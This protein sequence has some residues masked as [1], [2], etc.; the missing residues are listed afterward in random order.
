MNNIENV[1]EAKK[2]KNKR[3]QERKTTLCQNFSFKYNF[4]TS[5]LKTH[6]ILLKITLLIILTEKKIHK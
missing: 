1:R 5:N 4:K 6:K 2:Q 3:N